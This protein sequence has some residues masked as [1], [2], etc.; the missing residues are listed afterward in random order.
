MMETA[1]KI[2]VGLI[3]GVIAAALFLTAFTPI[4]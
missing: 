1:L 2:I 3:G 4:I